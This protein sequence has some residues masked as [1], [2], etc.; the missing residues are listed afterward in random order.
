M[1]SLT[2][3][4]AFFCFLSVILSCNN[5]TEQKNDDN[6][7]TI[8][9]EIIIFH[10]G[11]MAL[12]IKQINEAFN[13]EYPDVKILTESAGSVSCARKITDLG[14]MCDIFISA[15]YNVINNL[16]I[17]QYASWNIKFAS[18]EM[19]LVY[20]ESSKYANT[21]NTEN[22]YEIILRDDVRIGRSDPNADPCGYRTILTLKLAEKYYH[23]DKILS[24]VLLKDKKYMRPKEVDLLALLETN[25]VDYIFLYKSVAVQHNL[26]Y[27][28]LA[29][30]INL[31]SEKF[32][33]LYASVDVVINGKKPGEYETISGETMAY[34]I[35][36]PKNAP[37]QKAALAY[38]DYFLAA[39]GGM[40]IIISN[41]QSS[42]I[43][44][45][46]DTYL[47]VPDNLKKYVKKYQ[48]KT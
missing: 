24:Q 32:S 48:P 41:G 22:W 8:G 40:K 15:D 13:K 2:R 14:K 20:N 36:I 7:N 9:G 16:L 5:R 46:T 34:G 18:N 19:A 37:N 6:T 47:N 31:K 11:S 42:L 33:N 17:P 25:S 44:S 38:I 28:T 4:F 12:P 30:E 10:A 3:K 43:P 39:E 35:T 1:F 23:K 29:D 26:K 27:I 45:Y 21:I